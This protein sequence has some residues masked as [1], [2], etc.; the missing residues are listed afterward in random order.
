MVHY[1]IWL[2]SLRLMESNI[3]TCAK[4][5]QFYLIWFMSCFTKY[6]YGILI[7]AWHW[8]LMK[9]VEIHDHRNDNWYFSKF[10]IYI[11]RM[12]NWYRHRWHV[13]SVGSTDA[14]TSHRSECSA[15]V[16][17]SAR[18]TSENKVIYPWQFDNE[19]T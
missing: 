13:A 19:F 5:F 18:S 6:K 11:F 10:L 17:L 3:E 14:S 9:N 15:L 12:V 7:I 4:Y 2:N 1:C 8:L 16:G